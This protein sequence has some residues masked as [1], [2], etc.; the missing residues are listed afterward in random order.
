MTDDDFSLCMLNNARR[1]ARAVSRRYDRLVRSFGLKA[2]QFSV[3]ILVRENP[4]KTTGE[5]AEVFSIE[6]TTLVRNLA[7]LE[8]NGLV[9]GQSAGGGRGRTY[10]LT[11]AG[12]DLLEQALPVWRKA[13]ADMEAELGT[14][15]FHTTVSVLQRLSKV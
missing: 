11:E 9:A 6:R 14:E 13:Q 7:L 5:L 2:A 15:R 1:A 8:K 3:L 12:H 4:G 10:I